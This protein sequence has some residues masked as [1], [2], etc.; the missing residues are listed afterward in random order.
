MK[1]FTQY[2]NLVTEVQ[3]VIGEGYYDGPSIGE[4]VSRESQKLSKGHVPVWYL[5]FGSFREN[6]KDS[7]KYEMDFFIKLDPQVKIG[8]DKL[9]DI[10]EYEKLKP[11]KQ[12]IER[13]ERIVIRNTPRGDV[14]MKY[15]SASGKALGGIM[16]VD[17]VKK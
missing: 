16:Y 6:S 2:D 4:R 11:T 15:G 10:F 8:N 13:L 3:N 5:E 9:T 12:V 1:T 7:N 17:G 14:K